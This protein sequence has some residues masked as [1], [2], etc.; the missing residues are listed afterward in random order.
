MSETQKITVE[1]LINAPVEKVWSSFTE[2]E[3]ITQWNAA[4][5]DWHTPKADNDLRVGG[6]FNYWM[7]ARDGSVG[8]DFQ[9]TYEEVREHEYIAYSLGD[10]R[11]VSVTFSEENGQTRVVETFDPETENP[12]EM[13]RAGWQAILDNFKRHTESV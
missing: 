7:E 6:R 13:Q 1:T 11:K 9:G 12:P 10:A 5:P 8:F 4:S 3:H 2:P